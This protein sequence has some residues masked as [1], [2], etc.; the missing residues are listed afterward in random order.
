[1]GT[2]PLSCHWLPKA[3]LVCVVCERH[4]VGRACT[5]SLTHVHLQG[6]CVPGMRANGPHCD[7]AV[8]RASVTGARFK[9]V[10]P[11]KL[12]ER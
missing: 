5:L 7:G 9:N 11:W 12:L 1:M 6:P 3:A 10:L 4:C 8:A 2:T